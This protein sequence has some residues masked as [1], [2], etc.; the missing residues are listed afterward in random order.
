M[1]PVATIA[2]QTAAGSGDKGF[3]TKLLDSIP[4]AFPK[5]NEDPF[6]ECAKLRDVL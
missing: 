4:S 2:S 6:G 5:V 3:F 1:D